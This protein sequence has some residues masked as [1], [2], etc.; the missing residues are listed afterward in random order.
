M[1]ALGRMHVVPEQVRVLDG[2]KRRAQ[3]A[4]CRVK[5]S[6]MNGRR[7]EAESCRIADNLVEKAECLQVEDLEAWRVQCAKTGEHGLVERERDPADETLLRRPEYERREASVRH[8]VEE[9]IARAVVVQVHDR[10]DR[11]SR[12]LRNDR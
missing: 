1:P 4:G 10:A 12:R 11:V 2:G 8:F 9:Q 5:A 7:V 3:R 6:V